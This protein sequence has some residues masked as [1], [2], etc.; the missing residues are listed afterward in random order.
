MKILDKLSK[1]IS[2]SMENSASEEARKWVYDAAEL[3][4]KEGLNI[5]MIEDYDWGAIIRF[6]LPDNPEKEADVYITYK[7]VQWL[8]A[9]DFCKTIA[10][11]FSTDKGHSKIKYFL[12]ELAY[13]QNLVEG[14]E[15][16]GYFNEFVKTFETKEEVVAEVKSIIPRIKQTSEKLDRIKSEAEYFLNNIDKDK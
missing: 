11:S 16:D 10:T 5:Y 3:A 2:E 8:G 13:D 12:E 9:S 14:Y 6:A 7:R 4:K 1:A 15:F